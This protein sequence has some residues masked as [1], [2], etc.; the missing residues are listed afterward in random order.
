MHIF[1][2]CDYSYH[3]YWQNLISFS[4]GVRAGDRLTFDDITISLCY[5]KVVRYY[6]SDFSYLWDAY[7][8]SG[9][10]DDIPF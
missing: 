8:K 6:R 4:F 3:L 1:N 9:D 10:P 2:L 7:K 5:P